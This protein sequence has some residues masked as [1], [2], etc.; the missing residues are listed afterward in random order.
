MVSEACSLLHM[1]SSNNL[2]IVPRIRWLNLSHVTMI[3]IMVIVSREM[4]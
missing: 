1:L 4:R 3:L 2:I